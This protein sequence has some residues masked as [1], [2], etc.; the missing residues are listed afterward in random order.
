MTTKQTK[1]SE[2]RYRKFYET[3]TGLEIPDNHEIHHLDFNRK[4][5][6]IDNLVALP[7]ELH[8]KYHNTLAS[9]KINFAHLTEHNDIYSKVCSYGIPASIGYQRW[10][11][12]TI[13]KEANIIDECEN[14]IFKCIQFRDRYLK[15]KHLI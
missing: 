2:S 3:V 6:S 4:N 15:N 1:C 13:H 14:E 9:A 8:R 5:N 11:I 12:D 7:K 10:L